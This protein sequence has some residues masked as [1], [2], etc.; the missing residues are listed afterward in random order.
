[1][2]LDQVFERFVNKTPFAVMSRSLL[3]RTLAP[4][5][6]D[7]LFDNKADSQYTRELTFSSVVDLMGLVVTSAFPSV[8]AAYLDKACD[9]AVSLTSLYNKLQGIE[10]DVSAELVRH[11]AQQLL[12]L[13][14]H[15]GGALPE[16]VAGYEMNVL[17]GNAIAATEHRLKETRTNSAA[18]LPGKSL[19]VFRP[20][21]QLVTH[22]V[23]CEDGHTQERAL[24]D[25]ILKLVTKDSLWVADRN[26]CFQRF[27]LGIAQ[28]L[29]FF[30]I[31]EHASLNYKLSGKL[32]RRGQSETGEIFQQ[33][34]V[35][36]DE[37]GKKHRFRRIV[38]KL[39]QATE[40]G[41]WELAIL[42][43]L[44]KSVSAVVVSEAYRKRWTIEGGFQDLTTT[45]ACE[46]N[47]L[48]YPRAALFVFCV[49]LLAYNLQSAIK[50]V[51][52]SEHGAEKVEN[53]LSRYFVAGE[54]GQVYRGM[55][56]ALPPEEWVVVRDMSL[57]DYIAFLKRL[58]RGVDF[59]RYPKTR[60][61]PKK[62]KPKRHYDPK[63]P[64]VSVAKLLFA[65]NVKRTG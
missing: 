1:M 44:P 14:Q 11:T 46:I 31:R 41:D 45:L 47:T 26:F 5:A 27:L 49:A 64:H 20:A 7:A 37:E 19:C 58:A 6:V 51:M 53:E 12:P 25:P 22:V 28:Q 38:V 48:C 62:A 9:I 55:M 61:G 30:V 3:E 36:E 4:E 18:P 34:I 50:G 16:P 60:R 59:E 54:I 52:R 23:P 35:I 43:N 32:R 21:C 13:I 65:R 29:G 42:T 17:D 63:H 57:N 40:D 2:L 39:K 33:A 24:V 56:V 10:P 15:I 8:R